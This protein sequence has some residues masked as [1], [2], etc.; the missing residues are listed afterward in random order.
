MLMSK[1]VQSPSAK[2]AFF[3][4]AFRR[5]LFLLVLQKLFH[6]FDLFTFPL[7]RN[8]FIDV[9]SCADRGVTKAFADVIQ[10]K[11]AGLQEH[12]GVGVTERMEGTMT[13][14]PLAP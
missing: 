6:F 1:K 13:K 12:C 5:R 2:R 3:P 9:S 10:S 8:S 11:I 14:L 4:P 7:W